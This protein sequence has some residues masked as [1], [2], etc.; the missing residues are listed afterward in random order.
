MWKWRRYG[1]RGNFLQISVSFCHPPV[2][3]CL[4]S[5]TY[6]LRTL[7]SENQ[8]SANFSNTCLMHIDETIW[9]VIFPVRSQLEYRAPF[10]V[11]V[12]TYTKTHD[13]TPLD[14]WSAR[15]RGLYLH[16]RTQQTNIH[17]AS[18]IRSRDPSNQPAADLRLRPRGHWDRRDNLKGRIKSTSTLEPL[19]FYLLLDID[20]RIVLH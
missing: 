2:T 13:R 11:S 5:P 14:E 16:R 7:F 10:G 4:L 17:A 6:L 9:I 18:G 8:N 15:R 1:N 12:I 3:S 19:E 20:L